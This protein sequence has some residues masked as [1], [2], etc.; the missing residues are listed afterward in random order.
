M[1]NTFAPMTA[2]QFRTMLIAQVGKPYFLGAE[3]SPNDPNPP[4]FDC[5]EIIEWAFARNGTPIGD[6]AAAQYDKT[7]ALKPGESPRVGDL[8]FLK[9][10]PARWNRIGH[11]AVITAKL[12]SGDY[13]IVEARGRRYGVVRSSLGYWKTRKYFTGVR[14]FDKFRLATP[15]ETDRLF[16]YAWANG[17]AERWGGLNDNSP[18]RAQELAKLK[19][20][21]IGVAEFS[22]RAR[23]ATRAELGPEWLTWP[24]G[25]CAVLWS[26]KS[27]LHGGHAEIG[28]GTDYHGAVRVP[29]TSLR[30]N[31]HT[32][33]V[34][35]VHVRPADSYPGQTD[36]YILKRKREQ[37]ER[38]LTELLRPGKPTIVGGDFN[39][40]HAADIFTKHGLVLAVNHR[41]DQIWTTPDIGIRKGTVYDP[42]NVSDHK[43]LMLQGTLRA[44]T[45]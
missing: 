11:A 28:F 16:T 4:R 44:D 40:T 26:N 29:L 5:S 33:D 17:R 19:P 34:I 15:A 27:W 38:T 25:Y 23:N 6:L 32:M 10:N 2:E 8:V 41:I 22:E 7:R 9:N 20:S 39:T 35:S 30:N 1:P 3:A 45:T 14:R 36:S 13:E 43:W 24:V 37:I 31:K 18:K 12:S 21:I 42:G